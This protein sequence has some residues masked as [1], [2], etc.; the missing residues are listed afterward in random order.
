MGY[1]A[2]TSSRAAD[3]GQRLAPRSLQLPAAQKTRQIPCGERVKGNTRPRNLFTRR[4]P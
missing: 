3:R 2:R 1:K 4:L